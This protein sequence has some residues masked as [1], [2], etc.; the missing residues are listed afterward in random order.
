MIVRLLFATLVLLGS[1]SFA[2]DDKD[3]HH[4]FLDTLRGGF[5]AT[6]I[7]VDEMKYVGNEYISADDSS[8]MRYVTS[9]VQRDL[10]FYA[11]FELVLIDSFYLK[12]YEIT[13]LGPRGW[14]K[15][16]ADYLV[17]L[18]AEFPG[19]NLRVVWR[20]FDTKKKQQFQQGRMEKRKRDW[21]E[22][23]HDVANDIVYYL[24]G[25]AGIFRSRI[26]YCKEVGKG[27][28]RAKELFISDYDGANERQ[29]TFTKTINISPSF[30]PRRGIAFFTSYLSGD[31]QLYKI[32]VESG[33]LTRLGEFPGI[34]TAPEVSP[35]GNKIACVLSKDGNSEVYVLDTKGNVI[36]RLTRHK[37]IDTAPTWSPDGRMIA[38]SSDRTGSPQVYLMDSDGL[39][40]R[41]LTYQGRYNDSPI[42]SARGD[43]ITFVT[44]TKR[45]R[46]DIASIDTSGTDFRVLTE[47]GQ[48][49]NPHFS[50]DG[51]HIIFSSSRLGGRDIFTMDI[52]GRN[53]R[54]VTRS[55]VCS[56]PTWGR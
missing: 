25:D 9:V 17:K 22:L 7:G 13:D 6:K 56:N 43:R 32:D 31:P 37:R 44:R 29:L 35:D 53:Q 42:W 33:E 50:P 40:V 45:G 34:V 28:D 14:K 3:V 16:G 30:H 19:D 12:I 54:R 20:L 38:F 36:K 48:N 23:A 46:F 15:M 26:V 2:K 1:E 24:T 4:V 49:E 51:K 5:E 21:R 55:R 39:N 52:T 10:D 47:V 11:G 27:D 41:R 8:Y 18:E